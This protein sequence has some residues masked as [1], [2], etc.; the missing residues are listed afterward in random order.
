MKFIIMGNGGVS[1]YFGGED[2]WFVARG[3][4]RRGLTVNASDEKFGVSP[5]KMTG[6]FSVI[7]TAEIILFCV[8]SYDIESVAAILA[9]VLSHESIMICEDYGQRLGTPTPT[10][11]AI[12]AALL[13]YHLKHPSK[14]Q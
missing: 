1:G 4:R 11:K 5:G 12:Y 10:H 13:P 3:S 6:N 14:K 9:H 2:V 7:E 8:K